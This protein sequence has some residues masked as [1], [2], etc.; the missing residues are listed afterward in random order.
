MDSLLVLDWRDDWFL[1]SV[2]RAFCVGGRRVSGRIGGYGVAG[3][4]ERFVDSRGGAGGGI[5]A[6]NNSRGRVYFLPRTCDATTVDE[7][8]CRSCFQGDCG[9]DLG[10]S[11]LFHGWRTSTG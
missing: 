2:A 6:R 7:A 5:R 11:P 3:F 1:D 9:S 4:Y 10:R 8:L